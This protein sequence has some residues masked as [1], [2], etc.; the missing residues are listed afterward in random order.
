MTREAYRRLLDATIHHL[1]SLRDQ[2][3]THV[4]IRPE[5]LAALQAPAASSASP[6]TR[7][8]VT[9]A[10]PSPATPP[11][12]SPP[13][14]QPRSS[15]ILDPAARRIALAELQ[16]AARH[17]IR[18]PALA[19][20]RRNVVFGTGNPDAQI[21]FVGEA[22]GVDEDRL[23][24]P[25]VGAAGELLTRILTAMGLSR[26]QVYVANVLK[27]RPDT[28]GQT[29]GNRKPTPIEMNTCL[30]FL[31][32]QI[33][34]IRPRVIV[35]LGASAVEG[36]LGRSPIYITKIR[37]QWLDLQ[38]IPLMPT[39]HPA[40]LLR[41]QS[42]TDKRCVWEDMLAVMERVGMPISP[43]QRG[44]FSKAS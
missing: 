14:P 13:T 6:A 12:P 17:C 15:P 28:P 35:G 39:Y 42:A 43:R 5:S 32:R 20:V 22:P 24:E 11:P 3:L 40:Y 18:C 2:G 23:G 7:P 44:F 21:L 8:P 41:T 16:D 38:G 27:C 26:D 19:A 9:A 31:Q 34:I 29:S 33:D 25:F 1:E 10:H 36:L 30:P 4:P 37:G